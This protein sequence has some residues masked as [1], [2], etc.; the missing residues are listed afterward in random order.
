MA[1][2]YRIIN[3]IKGSSVIVMQKKKNKL[4]SKINVQIS[5]VATMD[6]PCDIVIIP[7]NGSFIL[8]RCIIFRTVKYRLRFSFLTLSN[9]SFRFFPY[10]TNARSQIQRIYGND[11]GL[12]MGSFRLPNSKAGHGLLFKKYEIVWKMVWQNKNQKKK[13]RFQPCDALRYV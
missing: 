4:F 1:L 13:K 11:P 3:I 2:D 9:I 5:I 10:E 6:D 7:D 12:G 8:S